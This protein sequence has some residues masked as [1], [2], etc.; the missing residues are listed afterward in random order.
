MTTL[1]FEHHSRKKGGF[2]T[3]RKS[4]QREKRIAFHKFATMSSSIFAAT[5]IGERSNRICVRSK[6]LPGRHRNKF[7]KIITDTHRQAE[8]RCVNSRLNPFRDGRTRRQSA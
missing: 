8:K 2:K 1:V 3:Q 7:G 4:P 6:Y 5:T